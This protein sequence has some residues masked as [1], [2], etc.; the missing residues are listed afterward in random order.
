MAEKGILNLVGDYSKD[1]ETKMD[2]QRT[3]NMYIRE[4][5]EGKSPMVLV[6]MAGR[7]KKHEFVGDLIIRDLFEYKNNL[8]VVSS[9]SIYKI[10]PSFTVTLIGTISSANGY[11]GR[12][13]NVNQIIWVDN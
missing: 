3:V 2:A 4:T 7:I 11:I 8:Y 13:G 6:P 5:P 10:D 12:T 9:S 1:I